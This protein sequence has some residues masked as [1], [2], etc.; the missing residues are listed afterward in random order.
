MP[1]PNSSLH[2]RQHRAG[3]LQTFTKAWDRLF[4]ILR[5]SGTDRSATQSDASS[6][7]ID[8]AV[9]GKGLS[10][11]LGDVKLVAK[12]DIVQA[13]TAETTFSASPQ[14]T[15]SPAHARLPNEMLAKIFLYA[16]GNSKI[17]IPADLNNI[18]PW[19]CARVC[20]SWKA[21]AESMPE[22]WTKIAIDFKKWSNYAGHVDLVNAIL[23]RHQQSLIS[24]TITP[25]RGR[26]YEA[27]Q[28]VQYIATNLLNPHSNQIK[29]L[30]FKRGYHFGSFLEQAPGSVNS[31]ET[32]R[33]TLDDKVDNVSVFQ[34]APSLRKVSI[35]LCSHT[36][37][38]SQF[39]LLALPL[40]WSQLTRIHFPGSLF[41]PTDAFALLGQT[42]NLEDCRIGITTLGTEGSVGAPDFATNPITLLAIKSLVVE[43]RNF[44]SSGQPPSGI[45]NLLSALNFPNLVNFKISQNTEIN[46]PSIRWDDMEFIEFIQRCSSLTSL[47]INEVVPSQHLERLLRSA[48]SLVKLSI[49]YGGN[50]SNSAIQCMSNPDFLPNLGVL[51]CC[52]D[53][54][55]IFLDML[56]SRWATSSSPLY[57]VS[58]NVDANGRGASDLSRRRV[59]TLIEKGRK[60]ILQG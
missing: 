55:H 20:S 52:I 49:R 47:V 1:R 56:E 22:L 35:D 24:L 5:K 16:S 7:G 42:I 23:S 43:D 36:Q 33:W 4:P 41:T 8:S 14:H 48:P 53:D 6:A 40:P 15:R 12:I 28:P 46:G 57:E 26:Y 38:F 31:L 59:E 45:T 29:S 19:N 13:T 39:D 30:C 54:L 2:T 18:S 32:L 27:Y 11:D 17:D 3:M 58:I 44:C 51:N 50:L 25:G 37:W 10:E 34:D 21:V 9:G 60:I